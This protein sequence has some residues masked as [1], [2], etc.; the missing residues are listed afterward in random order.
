MLEMIP[1]LVVV[2]PNAVTALRPTVL[3]R[4]IGLVDSRLESIS[5][6]SGEEE[7]V[8]RQFC[9]RPRTFSPNRWSL[10]TAAFIDIRLMKF[11]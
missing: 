9:P 3:L 11:I 10:H 2:V 7:A 1:A 4:S 5:C 6:C 8:I